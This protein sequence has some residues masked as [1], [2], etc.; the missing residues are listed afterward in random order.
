MKRQMEALSVCERSLQESSEALGAL[1]SKVGAINEDL[2]KL[3]EQ[4]KEAE[5]RS[6]TDRC[7]KL[8]AMIKPIAVVMLHF[9]DCSTSHP[10]TYLPCSL[11]L[12]RR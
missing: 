11:P 2:D 1:D 6:Q 7:F 9:S 3:A 8:E 4:M 5:V 10:P 12:P